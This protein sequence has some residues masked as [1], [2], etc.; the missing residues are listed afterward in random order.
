MTLNDLINA[1]HVRGSDAYPAMTTKAGVDATLR[2]LGDVVAAE[3]ASGGEIT[4]PGLGKLKAETRAA[5]SGRNPTTGAEIAIPA[6][7]VAKFVAAKALK[8]ALA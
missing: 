4:L 1:I 7:T 2:A 5:R 6:K 3:L 8:D